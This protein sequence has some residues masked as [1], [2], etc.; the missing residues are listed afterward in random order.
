MIKPL[1]ENKLITLKDLLVFHMLNEPSEQILERMNTL[2]NL[3][4][5]DADNTNAKS[6]LKDNP[7]SEKV[8]KEKNI[9]KQIQADKAT[10]PKENK[11]KVDWK[12]SEDVINSMKQDIDDILFFYLNEKNLNIDFNEIDSLIETI[13]EITISN[14]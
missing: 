14:Y 13:I 6:I 11:I 12:Q 2:L 1:L 3:T 5:K 8:I 9:M 7:D 4:G 10:N